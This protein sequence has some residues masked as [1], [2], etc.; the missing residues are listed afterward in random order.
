[1]VHW[2][3]CSFLCIWVWFF[4]CIF[5]TIT[6]FY[7]PTRFIG[8][9]VNP[10]ISYDARKLTWISR[11]IKKKKVIRLYIFVVYTLFYYVNFVWHIKKILKNLMD[12]YTERDIMWVICNHLIVLLAKINKEFN[13]RPVNTWRLMEIKIKYQLKCSL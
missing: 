12:F 5:V 8:C 1:M 13:L 9:S 6:V 10:E 4:L 2:G 3:A 11:V 7:L